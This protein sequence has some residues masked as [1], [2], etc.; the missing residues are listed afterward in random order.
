MRRRHVVL[1]ALAASVSH[2]AAA[3]SLS[4]QEPV[5]VS[6]E[7][8]CDSCVITLDTIL[9]IGGLEGRGLHVISYFSLA[10]VDRRGRILVMDPTQPDFSVFDSTGAFVRSVGRFGG[11]PGEYESLSLIDV[12]P[13]YIHVFDYEKSRTL[14]DHDFEVVRVDRLPAN[15]FST[16]VTEADDVVFIGDVG[17]PLAAG[18][19]LH[20]L[21]ASGELESF[22]DDASVYRGR[23]P[24]R[25]VAS[26]D[27]E[28]SLWAVRT[29][30]NRVTR[31]RL[32]PPVAVDRA[33]DRV[34]EA[35]E[36]DNPS[37][38]SWP[39][40]GNRAAM[41]DGDGLWIV[42]QTPDP[43]WTDR[44]SQGGLP[45]EP[46]DRILDGWIDLVDPDTGATLARHR[47][48]GI[49]LGFAQGSRYVLGYHETEAGV[50]Y[51]HLLRPELS[52][53]DNR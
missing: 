52:T 5:R 43:E 23:S 6:G 38:F 40:S 24:R 3:P 21:R 48:D 29:D 12:G 26:A 22:G 50:P 10:A 33:F 44:R 1:A 42:W 47:T 49:L 35:F 25:V 19:Q 31:W 37:T 27:G 46:W 51:L 17:T 30:S 36:R 28:E 39:R 11:G 34:V 20:I 8:T 18:H 53:R 15:V 7:V 9:T 32:S 41:V 45:T 13:R 2:G 4:A 14:L 16:V